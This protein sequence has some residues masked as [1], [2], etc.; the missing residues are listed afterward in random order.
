MTLK[1]I[2][3]QVTY[4]SRRDM[5]HLTTTVRCVGIRVKMVDILI[6]Q[7]ST[8]AEI[9]A[10]LST[11]HGALSADKHRRYVT[12]LHRVITDAVVAGWVDEIK[13][14][15]DPDGVIQA[16]V[17][18]VSGD[19]LKRLA[20]EDNRQQATQTSSLCVIS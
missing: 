18:T 4:T 14:A 19:I 17:L 6:T 8:A 15:N 20:D 7:H 3:P 11:Y 9:I 10:A 2:T 13:D 12:E 5:C 1:P 16:L